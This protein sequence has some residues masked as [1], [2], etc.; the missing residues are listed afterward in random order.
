MAWKKHKLT[1]SRLMAWRQCPR[2]L[3]L[4]THR[5][6]LAVVD[7]GSQAI[8][9]SG[10]H[11]G[12]VARSLF[13][14]GEVMDIRKGAQ[15]CIETTRTLMEAGAERI[16]EAAFQAGETLVLVD[17]LERVRR[18]GKPRYRVV[19]VKA[20]TSVKD[21]Y[22]EDCAIQS[23]VLEQSIGMVAEI[24]L[25][26]VN[27]QFVYA[28]DGD[29]IGLLVEH[30]VDEPIAELRGEIA[31]W[32]K[33]ATVV[34][35]GTEPALAVGAHCN[36]PYPCPFFAHCN[37][38]NAVDYPVSALPRAK[39]LAQA[40][41]AD[42]Y[43]DLRDVPAD[44]LIEP[45]HQRIQQATIHQKPFLDTAAAK[46]LEPLGWPRYYLDFETIAFSV[47]IWAATRPFQQLPFQWSLHIEHA[48]GGLEHREFLDVSGAPPMQA[49][50]EDLIRDAGAS[51]PIFVYS[52]FE[53]TVLNNMAKQFPHLGKALLAIVG[54]I[55]DL[56]P[57]TREHY[58]HSEMMGSWSIK[59]VLPT[60]ASDLS[61]EN[62][63]IAGGS[64]AQAAYLA[65]I[66][67]K[68]DAVAR[69]NLRGDLL[70]YCGQDTLAMVRLHRFLSGV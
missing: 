38:Q 65:A 10:S 46:E 6:D 45:L 14:P 53:K 35:D 23:H 31:A 3:W 54:R 25:G 55:Y 29:Y 37:D 39:K 59:K 49:A 56:L 18:P 13:G 61:Y 68:T 8:M 50:M 60:I 47:P 5:P 44:R 24:S 36:K 2:K 40:L 62:L 70:D 48:D 26:L 42:G 66:N 4:H 58:Y 17:V 33:S 52:G 15:H 11:F 27:N 32:I 9:D 51:G 41:L 43:E 16:F 19:E 21:P 30:P 12:E 63:P 7:A 34:V 28:G 64:A 69:E 22:I 67:T 20:S 57:L 1:K